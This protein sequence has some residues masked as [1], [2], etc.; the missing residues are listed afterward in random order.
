[1]NHRP[2]YCAGQSDPRENPQFRRRWTALRSNSTS[3]AA[4]AAV[5]TSN[6]HSPSA[7]RPSLA[8]IKADQ[9]WRNITR[10]TASEV[11]DTDPKTPR[12]RRT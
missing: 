5:S 1:M 8:R 4:G 7:P 11:S 12:R 2:A 6:R 10:E 3:A 9:E